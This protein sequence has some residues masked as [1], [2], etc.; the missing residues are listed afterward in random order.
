MVVHSDFDGLTCA[1]LLSEI[2]KPEHI[3]ITEPKNIRDGD[4]K[5]TKED[6]VADLPI[7][8][9]EVYMAFDHHSSTSKKIIR[10][11]WFVIDPNAPSCARVIYNEYEKTYPAIRKWKEL[12]HWA[13]KIDSANL[14]IKEYESENPYTKISMTFSSSDRELDK[15]Y[16]QYLIRK[17]LEY[18]SVEKASKM[19]WV[20]GRYKYRQYSIKRWKL[21]ITRYITVD[22]DVIITD[23]RDAKDFIPRGNS[24]ELYKM[25]PNTSVSIKITNNSKG[26]TFISMSENM[27]HKN[28]NRVH[29]GDIAARYN[30]GG[31][32]GASGCAV[33]QNEADTVIKRIIKE[34]KNGNKQ[35]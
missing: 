33:N 29:L 23:I 35:G 16:M 24:W 17:I 31:H 12:V 2:F 21:V 19:D 34:I 25:Y 22:D 1:V 15:F 4:V 26:E 7:P 6:I 32:K 3:M 18:K 5:L 20:D 27:F 9:T 11:G 30:G 10:G 14:T 13:D 8:S 28:R